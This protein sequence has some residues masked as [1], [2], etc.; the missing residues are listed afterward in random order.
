MALVLEQRTP[1]LAHRAQR[2]QVRPSHAEVL[3]KMPPQRWRH[4]AH[5]FEEAPGHAQKTDLQRQ[6]EL[7]HRT[8]PVIDHTPFSVREVEKRLDLTGA[9]IARQ[10]APPQTRRM[11]L[12]HVPTLRESAHDTPAETPNSKSWKRLQ[13]ARTTARITE[14]SYRHF[15]QVNQGRPT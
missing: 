15:W 13:K 11:P 7:E 9:Q 2:C 3:P 12:L 8:A 10:S 5:R 1:P 6:C 4:D 14:K